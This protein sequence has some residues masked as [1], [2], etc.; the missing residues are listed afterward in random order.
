MPTILEMALLSMD[1]YEKFEGGLNATG[2][3]G[4][5]SVSGSPSSSVDG[6]FAH[7]QN[8]PLS[9]LLQRRRRRHRHFAHAR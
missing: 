7:M 9:H 8:R 3:L 5:F 2:G 6:F 1:V 4:N